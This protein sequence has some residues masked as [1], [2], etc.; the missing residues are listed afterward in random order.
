MSNIFFIADTHFGHKN[1]IGYTRPGF[2]SIEAHNVT[3]VANIN[4]VVG[5]RDVLWH[6]GDVAFGK[7]NLKYLA[8]CNGIKK[9]VMGNHDT[10]PATEYLK[11]F[12][13]I[14]GAAEYKGFVLTHIPI[15]PA[16]FSRYRGNI[17]GHIHDSNRF[18]F[19]KYINVN[20]E[21]IN[22]TPISFSS[23][24]ERWN[25]SERQKKT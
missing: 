10:Y 20:C 7:D 5:K 2:E 23:I 19:G 22:L 24:M 11:Y 9:L 6:L 21:A 12:S 4:S 1:I 16:Q 18:I 14:Y 13:K 8:E 25:D 17:H 3:L 15:D